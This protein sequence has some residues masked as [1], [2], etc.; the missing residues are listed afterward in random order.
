MKRLL[1]VGLTALAALSLYACTGGDDDGGGVS[2]SAQQIAD[3]R[4]L[5]ESDITA[6]LKTFVPSGG[7]DDYVMF[8]SGGH[9]GQVF[10]IGLPSMRLLKTIAVFTPEAWQGYGIGGGAT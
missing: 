3:D 7:R 10:A 1:L 9:S 8:A 4:G 6:A 5:T 2:D